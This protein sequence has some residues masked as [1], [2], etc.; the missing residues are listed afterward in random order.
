MQAEGFGGRGWAI[1][2]QQGGDRD[3]GVCR[4]GDEG[5]WIDV[6]GFGEAFEPGDGET[7]HAGF[8]AT[9]GDGGGLWVTA[10]GDI[11]EGEAFGFADFAQAG[12]HGRA[13]PVCG[14]FLSYTITNM[15]DDSLLSRE[16]MP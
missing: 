9:D 14:K 16:K 6:Q 2:Q 4:V 5:F 11:S 1:D 10:G 3:G 8:E 15:A 12:H 7:A 13:S